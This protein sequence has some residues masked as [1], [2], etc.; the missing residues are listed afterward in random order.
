M[1]DSLLI[2]LRREI[3]LKAVFLVGPWDIP[4]EPQVKI[5][6]MGGQGIKLGAN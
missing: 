4:R 1:Q 2:P 3:V 6:Q 5:I